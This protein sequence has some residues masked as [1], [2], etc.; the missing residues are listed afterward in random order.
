MKV[1]M[2]N[3]GDWVNSCKLR[4]EAVMKKSM[5]RVGH[6]SNKTR[7]KG[8]RMPVVTG[9][10]RRSFTSELNGQEIGGKQDPAVTLTTTLAS[11]EV[12]DV[13]RFKWS[14]NYARRV[15]SGFVGEDSLGRTYNQKGHHFV[16]YG[17]DQWDKIVAEEAEEARRRVEG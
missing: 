12:G 6:E 16:E 4:Q 1:L 15:N 8:G 14:T 13:V 11:T 2:A 9:T 10:L 17:T 3:M 5:E 7:V